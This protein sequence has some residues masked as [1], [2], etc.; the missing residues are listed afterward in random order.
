VVGFD[1][2]FQVPL[3]DSLLPILQAEPIDAIVHTALADG[4]HAFAVNV[5]GT[6]AWLEEAKTA[7]IPLQI[8]LSTLS[9]EPDALSDYGR[10]KYELEQRFVAAQQVVFR[11]GV[12]IGDGGMF[13]RIRSSAT[14]LPVTPMLDGGK[15]LLYVVGIDTLC[16]V[17]CDTIANQGEGLRG[18]AWNLVQPQPVTLREM[19]A[20]INRGRGRR[21]VAVPVPTKPVVALLRVVESLPAYR[22]PVTSANVRGL[23]QQ[24]Q[25]RLPSDFGRFGYP[26]QPLDGLIASA[27][28]FVPDR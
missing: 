5:D 21:T 9:A 11:L 2:V 19:V 15:Q 13:E 24:G 27:S 7:G 22:L 18:R 1:R 17:L 6:T 16:R 28:R 12:V 23:I 20:A 3:G 8:F 10:S 25:K 26:E 14:R 4:P